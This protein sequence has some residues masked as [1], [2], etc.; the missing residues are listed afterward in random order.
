MLRIL[1]A[2]LVSVELI[3]CKE[4]A[5]FQQAVERLIGES[6][7]TTRN[8]I[9][10]PIAKVALHGSGAHR[11]LSYTVDQLAVKQGCRVAALIQ[12]LPSILFADIYQLQN[13]ELLRKGPKVELIG[14]INLESIENHSEPSCLIVHVAEDHQLEV[15]VHARYP[16][17]QN[18]VSTWRSEYKQVSLPE[19]FVFTKCGEAWT[20]H[21]ADMDPLQIW[22]VPV[23]NLQHEQFVSR[24]TIVVVICASVM[25]LKTAI[26]RRT[27]QQQRTK[28]KNA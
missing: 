3:A 21:Q 25:V 19:P 6:I 28:I 15:D 12:P 13:N 8:E 14:T 24:A 16:I 17:P 4:A 11:T 23:G 7:Y 20:V 10:N 18:G 22:A 2:L 27:R 9:E 5:I 26:L 1:L